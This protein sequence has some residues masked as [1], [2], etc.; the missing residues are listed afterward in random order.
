MPL[1]QTANLS[2][3]LSFL[4]RPS[5]LHDCFYHL[6][7]K[8]R[9]FFSFIIKFACRLSVLEGVAHKGNQERL[10]SQDKSESVDFNLPAH[11][12]AGWIHSVAAFFSFLYNL[13]IQRS[14]EHQ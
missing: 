8:P 10:K 1:T 6:P 9:I 2:Q 14:M 7:A 12:P 5:H 11:L 4:V 3:V 13:L